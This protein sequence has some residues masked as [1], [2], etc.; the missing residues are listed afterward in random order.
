[1]TYKNPV[2]SHEGIVLCGGQVCG[3]ID[4]LTCALQRLRED[5]DTRIQLGVYGKDARAWFMT[6][7]SNQPRSITFP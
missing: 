3:Q 5:V 4:G 6:I 1:V 2:S 7:Y